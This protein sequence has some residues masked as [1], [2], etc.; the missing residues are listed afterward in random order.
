MSSGADGLVLTAGG[1]TVEG[2]AIT[3][4]NDGVLISG[5]GGDAV[6]GNFIGTTTA[7]NAYGY[8][9]QVGIEVQASGNT[10]GGTKAA[11]R[12][13]ISGNGNQ[14][15]RIDDGGSGNLVAG[16]YIGTDI[17]GANRLGNNNGGVVLLDAPAN[18]IGGSATG[19]GNVISANGNDGIQVSSANNGPGSVYTVILGNII[20]LDATGTTGLGNSN[21]GVEVDFGAGTL[22][23]GSAKGDGN[24]ISGNTAGVYLQSS[25]IGVAVQGN[26]IGTDARGYKAIGNNYDGVV[27]GGS[28]NTVGGSVG[29]AGNVISGNGRDG[30]SDGVYSGSTGNNTVAGNLIG[31]DS[32]G[33]LAIANNQDGIEIGVGGDVVG[34]TASAARN[35]IS[36][37]ARYGVVI[38]NN[39]VLTLVEGN[40]IGTDKTGKNPL[41]NGSD[42]VH[43]QNN[44]SVSTIGGSTTKAGNIIAFNGGTG[45]SVN[46]GALSN[47]ILTNS[48][49][50]NANQGIVLNGN[51]N[52]LQVAPVLSSAVSSGSGTVVQGRLTASPNTTYQL[53]FFANPTADP[54]GYGQGQTYLAS[55]T[56]TTNSSGVA[57]FS[58]TIKPAVAAGQVISATATSPAQNTSAF[59]ADVSVTDPKSKTTAPAVVTAARSSLADLGAGGL[60]VL[61]IDRPVRH[62]GD[63]TG[64][65]SVPGQGPRSTSGS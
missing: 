42:G 47:A 30:I 25:A 8:G 13:V 16:N 14:G 5:S 64:R 7:G 36:G 59:S 38:E 55:K 17:T 11:M 33:T 12:N 23:G 50:S 28:N 9:N 19:A 41:G 2:L 22:V 29:G 62:G 27:L 6:C 44:A 51:G 32:T 60:A 61:V 31:T 24:V 43:I 49:F 1:S 18:T 20:G 4:F 54:S 34:G 46:D 63:R 3:R 21:N 40:D 35:V 26:L 53:Q 52:A 57:S 56:V 15:V 58:I 39:A 65:G 48:I 37:N 45:V 10:V